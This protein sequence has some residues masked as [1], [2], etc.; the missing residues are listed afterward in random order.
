[1]P[2]PGLDR[3]GPPRAVGEIR[4]GPGPVHPGRRSGQA[5]VE[6]VRRLQRTVRRLARLV[7]GSARER[8]NPAPIRASWP[9]A[10]H[11][12][13]AA[14][15]ERGDTAGG[16]NDEGEGYKGGIGW[17]QQHSWRVVCP[18]SCKAVGPRGRSQLASQW[19]FGPS[20]TA[21]AKACPTTA[22]AMRSDF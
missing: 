13:A 15:S 16:A 19:S 7:S 2:W 10:Q 11:I 3:P 1:M 20:V 9:A 4:V 17:L 14:W 8:R 6:T 22:T 12:A 18:S 5:P 21:F